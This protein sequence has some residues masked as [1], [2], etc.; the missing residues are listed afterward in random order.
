MLVTISIIQIIMPS[1]YPSK[2]L[3]TRKTYVSKNKRRRKL[4]ISLFM[5]TI[6][7]SRMAQA[8]ID[9]QK[10]ISTLNLDDD[11]EMVNHVAV[12]TSPTSPTHE[13][14]VTI[15]VGT[16]NGVYYGQYTPPAPLTNEELMSEFVN[17]SIY[18]RRGIIIQFINNN[19]NCS[20]TVIGGLRTN[21]TDVRK[22][23]NY[24]SVNKTILKRL[25]SQTLVKHL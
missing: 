22:I 4:P 13:A 15:E 14:E 25:A 8:S 23:P 11:A 6:I 24:L 5:C 17:P 20:P 2:L 16:S 21:E 18:Q 19:A 7:D 12:Q 9:L 3:H 10:E 1:S